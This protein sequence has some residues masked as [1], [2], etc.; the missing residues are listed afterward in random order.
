MSLVGVVSDMASIDPRWRHRP[1]LPTYAVFGQ[2]TL[3]AMKCGTYLSK[4]S[5]LHPDRRAPTT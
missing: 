3:R 5:P 1:R 4:F 2:L